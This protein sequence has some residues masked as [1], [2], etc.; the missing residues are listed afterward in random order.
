LTSDLWNWRLS[1]YQQNTLDQAEPSYSQCWHLLP[2][3]SQCQFHGGDAAGRDFDRWQHSHSHP[4]E[5][6][7][8][9]GSSFIN[10]NKSAAHE[11]LQ[12]STAAEVSYAAQAYTGVVTRT[13]LATIAK[14]C[15]THDE[16]R[17]TE[18]F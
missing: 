17:I 8:E 3:N 13:G 16:R 14:T 18:C 15:G 7:G 1:G 10:L 6:P 11:T 5:L 9:S 12:V 2:L 4:D